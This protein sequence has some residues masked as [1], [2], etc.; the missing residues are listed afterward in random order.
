MKVIF[1]AAA[2]LHFAANVAAWGAQGHE[3]VGYVAMQ[4]RNVA[5]IKYILTTFL[6]LVLLVLGGK[7]RLVCCEYC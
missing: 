1:V 2:A 5:A 7:S 6:P 3:A 4:V